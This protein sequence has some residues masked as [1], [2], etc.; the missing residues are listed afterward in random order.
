MRRKRLTELFPWLLPLRRAQRKFCFYLAMRFDGNRYAKIKAPEKFP[1]SVIETGWRMINP[2]TGYDMQY[3]YNKVHNL[4]LAAATVDR[5]IIRPGETFSFWQRVR[6]ADKQVKY[7][8]GL[9]LKDGKIVGIYGGGLCQLSELLYW[10]FL[11]TPLTVTER[12]NHAVQA[13]PPAATDLPEGVDATVSEGW[14]DLK[15]KNET[16]AVYQICLWFDEETIFGGIFSSKEPD[17]AYTI[18]N[19][20][21]NAYEKD[22]RRFFE[23][24][25]LRQVRHLETDETQ[26]EFLYHDRWE[27]TY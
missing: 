1:Y 8:D 7:K 12:H 16:D 25:V 6:Y 18:Y 19:E 26:D 21:Y 11:H 4:K 23:V 17:V 15:V 13:F 27:A 5:I 3:Q 22:G 24:D 10:L 20:N 2:S 14:L 9:S